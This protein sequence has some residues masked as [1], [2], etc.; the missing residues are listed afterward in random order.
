MVSWK[1]LEGT[2]EESSGSALSSIAASPVTRREF[3]LTIG[4]WVAVDW[5]LY[6]DGCPTMGHE[7]SGSLV[8]TFYNL[9]S[10]TA[11]NAN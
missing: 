6:L 5:Q 9:F 11:D 3:Q 2:W 4:K 1:L 10:V 8:I 7:V